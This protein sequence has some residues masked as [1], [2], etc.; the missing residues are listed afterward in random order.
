MGHTI[1]SSQSQTSTGSEAFVSEEP[2]LP[3]LTLVISLIVALNAAS[4]VL[5]LL[6][7]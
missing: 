3:W 6:A 2:R 5:S 7:Y 4:L 1:R